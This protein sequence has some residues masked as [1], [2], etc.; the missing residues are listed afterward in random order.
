MCRQV[1]NRHKTI[2]YDQADGP[3]LLGLLAF[4]RVPLQ[5][6]ISVTCYKLATSCCHRRYITKADLSLSETARKMLQLHLMLIMLLYMCLL[7]SDIHF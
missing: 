6:K 5:S 3:D 1:N 4:Q 7:M 2:V